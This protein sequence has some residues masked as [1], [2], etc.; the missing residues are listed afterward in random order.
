MEGTGRASDA[1]QGQ[2]RREHEARL[3]EEAAKA[4][5]PPPPAPPG[6]V[7]LDDIIEPLITEE[8]NPA[9]LALEKLPDEDLK[10]HAQAIGI[11]LDARWSRATLVRKVLE[12]QG[13]VPE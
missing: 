12:K 11:K 2:F 1:Y 6:R 5:P 4:V 10:V 8:Q 13:G 7:K 3:A 9:V